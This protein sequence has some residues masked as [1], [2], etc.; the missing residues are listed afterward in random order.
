MG[1][2]TGDIF[3]IIVFAIIGLFI[4]FLAIVKRKPACDDIHCPVCGY[5][6]KRFLSLIA[7]E[8]VDPKEIQEE[9]KKVLFCG[10]SSKNGAYYCPRCRSWNLKFDA[11]NR[12][13]ELSCKTP[14]CDFSFNV[15]N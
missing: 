5:L 2:N 8:S 15:I 4:L 13:Q 6:G 1:I 7:I 3:A 12:G 9:A 10:C 11:D 14:N